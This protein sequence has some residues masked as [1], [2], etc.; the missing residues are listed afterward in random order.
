M[1]CRRGKKILIKKYRK[2]LAHKKKAVPL[3]PDLA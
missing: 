1:V 2:Y 3:S